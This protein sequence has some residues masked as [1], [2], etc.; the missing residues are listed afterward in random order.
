MRW[1]WG[2]GG[3]REKNKNIGLMKNEGRLLKSYKME[4]K[5]KLLLMFINEQKN[6]HFFLLKLKIKLIIE[7]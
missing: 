4:K 6:V 3:E 7:L 1:G 2:W 5:I